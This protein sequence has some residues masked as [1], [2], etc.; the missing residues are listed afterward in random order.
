MVADRYVKLVLTVIALELL[1]LGLRDAPAAHAQQKAAPMEVVVTGVRIGQQGHSMLP[2]VVMGGAQRLPGISD[3]RGVEPLVVRI[4]APIQTQVQGPLTL[5]Q[6][7]TVRT[8]TEPLIVRIPE[9][10]QAQVREP[11]TVN[12]PLTVRT[13]GEALVVDVLP[14]RPTQRPGLQ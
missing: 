4:P 11:V 7:L 14:G 6:P 3:V 12:Q 8:A 10:I 2:V 9:P 13:G 1:W 5:S